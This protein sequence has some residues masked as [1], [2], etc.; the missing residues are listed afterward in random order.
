[1]FDKSKQT[2]YV[3]EIQDWDS[4]QPKSEEL[5]SSAFNKFMSYVK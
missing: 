4:L 1:M 5:G 3:A 2:T